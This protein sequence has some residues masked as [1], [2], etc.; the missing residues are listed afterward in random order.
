MK[1]Q[2]F[3]TGGRALGLAGGAAAAVIVILLLAYAPRLD[4]PQEAVTTDPPDDVASSPA[5]IEAPSV[6]RPA[7]TADT[8][9][10]QEDERAAAVAPVPEAPSED[11]VSE[12]VADVL[13]EVTED[14]P[15]VA[16]EDVAEDAT[17]VATDNE[18]DVAEDAPATSEAA[19][20]TSP[21]LLFDTVRLAPDGEALVAGR[22][23][24]GSTVAV[25]LDGAEV[26]TATAGGDGAFV[27]FL[28]LPPAEGPRVLT[29]AQDR[30]G[31]AVISEAQ[32]IITP[33]PPAPPATAMAE[34]EA[35]EPPQAATTAEAQAGSQ[36]QAQTAD[37]QTGQPDDVQEA[38]LSPD[39]PAATEAAQSVEA[40]GTPDQAAASTTAPADPEPVAAAGTP[41]LLLS[42]SSGL[43]VLQ[44]A[45]AA[46]G[47]DAQNGIG[48]D[49]ISYSDNGDVLL[50]GR[51]QASGTVMIYIDNA[52][53]ATAQT[54]PDGTWSRDLPGVAAGIYTL[55]LD[56]VD[57]TGAVL[58]RI[59]TPFQRED[60]AAVAAMAGSGAAVQAET[61]QET[62]QDT[63]IQNTA[64]TEVAASPAAQTAPRDSSA[65]VTPTIRAVTV[66]PGNTLWAIARDNYGEGIL[67]VR[68]FDAN[69][70]RIRDPDLIYPG[71]IFE[72]PN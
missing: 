20:A 33:A 2:P 28:S 54:G 15:D 62:P 65:S 55:R 58:S 23:D 50:Q 61:P 57:A 18:T 48:L 44:P 34:S 11:V 6:V 52:L 70:D 4:P 45:T 13:D 22:A 39:T 32:V 38:A 16:S 67:Y 68:L 35:E 8:M 12:S 51:G 17:D 56:E 37:L 47:A 19:P 9:P 24:A 1:E 66:Q 7:E 53:A 46:Q 69:R 29:L 63:A 25:L 41:A 40:V 30:D 26:G 21:V 10:P 43:R 71:Q 14:A 49:V 31:T 3:L 36:P 64:P 59:E 60:R 27:A 72:I 42:D 5:Q